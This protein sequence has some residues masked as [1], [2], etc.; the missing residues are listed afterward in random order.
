[1]F[2]HKFSWYSL[3]HSRTTHFQANFGFYFHWPHFYVMLLI[4]DSLW[5]QCKYMTLRE[6]GIPWLI[7]PARLLILIWPV[8]SQLESLSSDYSSR[9]KN[10]IRLFKILLTFAF[11]WFD[12]L[13][14]C[15]TMIRLRQPASH[16]NKFPTRLLILVEV[17]SNEL[18]VFWQTTIL[19]RRCTSSPNGDHQRKNDSKKTEWSRLI[20]L[21]PIL[22]APTLDGIYQWCCCHGSQFQERC[23]YST[24][25]NSHYFNYEYVFVFTQRML[26]RDMSNNCLMF[27]MYALQ[28]LVLLWFVFVSIW[29]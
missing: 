26:S 23:S 10:A 18:M 3:C 24:V 27:I 17:A 8:L 29:F 19:W 16:H 12:L 14:P 28:Y 15:S 25:W 13:L 11:T 1:M 20:W 21:E 9:K 22:R 6:G 7:L 5:G 2:L 4:L